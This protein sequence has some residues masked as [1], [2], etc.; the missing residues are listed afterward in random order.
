MNLIKNLLFHIFIRYF[1]FIEILVKGHFE[2]VEIDFNKISTLK[3]LK[4]IFF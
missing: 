2:S 3:Y 4:P 1:K